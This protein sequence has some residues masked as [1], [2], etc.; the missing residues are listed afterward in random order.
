MT[1]QPGLGAPIDRVRLGVVGLGAVAQ[2]VHLPLIERLRGAFVI[3]GIADLS[4]TLTAAIGERYRV[5]P[6]RR[7]GTLE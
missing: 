2:A 3:A 4:P 6:D 1:S 7:F 5:G